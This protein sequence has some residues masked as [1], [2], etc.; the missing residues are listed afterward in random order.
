M[1]TVRAVK[2]TETSSRRSCKYIAS[3]I[4]YTTIM[5]RNCKSNN[6]DF[7]PYT[8]HPKNAF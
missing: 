2:N 3:L 5:V 1:W 8:K 6:I 4:K 7:V